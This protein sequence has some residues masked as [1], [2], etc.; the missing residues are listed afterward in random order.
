MQN[1]WIKTAA[2]LKHK[3]KARPGISTVACVAH[4]K[5]A[6]APNHAIVCTAANDGPTAWSGEVS[7]AVA[8]LTA[9]HGAV[10]SWSKTVAVGPV[11]PGEARRFLVLDAAAAES[12][13][14]GAQ[15]WLYGQQLMRQS[16]ASTAATE[17]RADI[18]LPLED[19]KSLVSSGKLPASTV[20]VSV[21]S[22]NAS[23]ASLAITASGAAALYVH[24]TTAA[25]GQFSESG[26]HLLAG[27]TRE[28][29]FVAWEEH[30][31]MNSAAFSKSLHTHW[32]NV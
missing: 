2:D 26:F 32:L 7:L 13:P 25:Q 30:R 1:C 20:T 9:E 28:L 10:P 27:E 18:G 11:P 3:Q 8:P 14:V 15:C 17:L 23:G 21:S 16:Y 31:P 24:L 6:P 5:P 4:G 29:S 22:T 19:I 12:C